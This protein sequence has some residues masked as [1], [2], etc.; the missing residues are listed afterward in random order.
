MGL[1]EPKTLNYNSKGF[2]SLQ[3]PQGPQSDSY[4]IYLSV[5]IIDDSDGKTNFPI[6]TPIQVLPCNS[7]SLFELILGVTNGSRT[8]MMTTMMMEL[9]S[10]NLN[11]ISKNIIT[12]STY[13][14]AQNPLGFNNEQISLIR[15][16]LMEKLNDLSVSDMSSIKVLTSTLS[17]LTAVPEQVSSRLGVYY[18]LK[19]KNKLFF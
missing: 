19:L 9:N 1:D 18:F 10:G 3:L 8:K 7:T 17:L 12:L 14:N 6:K 4:F 16:Y 2:V 13:L 15:E 5:N 11:L